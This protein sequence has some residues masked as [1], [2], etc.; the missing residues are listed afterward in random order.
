MKTYICEICGDAYIGDDK[1]SQCPFCGADRGFIK[2]GAEAKP[3]VNE[4]IDVNEKDRENLIKTYELEIH[5]N[6]TYLCMASKTKSYEIKAMYKRLGKVE[7]EHSVIVTKILK[8]NNLAN[9]SVTCADDD[10]E[11]FEATISLEDNASKLYT[12]FAQE[13]ENA[14]L[15]KFWGAL[16]IVEKEHIDLINNYQ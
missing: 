1:P 6:A 2:D 13:S 14:N 7:L 9:V 16:S 11:N 5:A 3:V 4:T 8:T 15:K 12:Q 10:K